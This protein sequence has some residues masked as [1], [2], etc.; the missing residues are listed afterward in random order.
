M[1]F[2]E[3]YGPWAVVT[4][5]AAGVGLAFVEELHPRGLGVVMVDVSSEGWIASLEEVCEGAAVGLAVANAGLGFNGWYLDGPAARRR[6]S[7]RCS[8][9]RSNPAT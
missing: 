3:R 1:S 7:R 9:H 2:V 4:G 8:S 5:V 6:A